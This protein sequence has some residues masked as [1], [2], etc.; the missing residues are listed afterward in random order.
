MSIRELRLI[1]KSPDLLLYEADIQNVSKELF[2][3]QIRQYIR[4]YCISSSFACYLKGS[5]QSS[6]LKYVLIKNISLRME[7]SLV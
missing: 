4:S 3:G 5:R 7:K 6:F 2:F 1:K